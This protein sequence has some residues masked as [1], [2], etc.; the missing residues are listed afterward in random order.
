MKE[1]APFVFP[2]IEDDD[3]AWATRAMELPE[4]A[5]DQARQQ[6]LKN[7]TSIDVAACPGSGKTTLL[8]AKLAILARKWTDI[9]SFVR[10]EQGGI[11]KSF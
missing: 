3:I 5:F 8:V 9:L 4:G 7:Q 11:K 2:E 6:V 10:V 1:P